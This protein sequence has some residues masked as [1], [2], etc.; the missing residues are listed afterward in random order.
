MTMKKKRLISRCVLE[1]ELSFAMQL[2]DQHNFGYARNEIEKILERVKEY[3][4]PG[5]NK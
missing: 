5:G 2:I 1:T 3:D 4:L